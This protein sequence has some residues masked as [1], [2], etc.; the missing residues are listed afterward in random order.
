MEYG[1]VFPFS[2]LNAAAFQNAAIFHRRRLHG[3]SFTVFAPPE[4]LGCY[5]HAN[6]L[7]PIDNL[8]FENYSEVSNYRLKTLSRRDPLSWF[9][10]QLPSFYWQKYSNRLPRSCYRLLPAFLQADF[11]MRRY[12]FRSGVYSRVKNSCKQR[13]IEFLGSAPALNIESMRS[14]RRGVVVDWELW[15][16]QLSRMISS[17]AVLN[18]SEIRRRCSGEIKNL[19]LEQTTTFQQISSFIEDHKDVIM[20]R[21]R[22]IPGI[23]SAYNTDPAFLLSSVTCFLERGFSVINSGTPTIHLEI[24]HKNLLQVDHNL[25]VLVQQ[26]LG[27][28]CLYVMTSAEGGLFVAWA[29]TSI[30]LI[31]FGIEWSVANTKSCISLLEARKSIGIHDLNLGVT[32]GRGLAY[33]LDNFLIHANSWQNEHG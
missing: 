15:F 19:S 11:K 10:S 1:L 20:V 13:S 16:E 28:K 14:I 22:N 6:N 5:F 33:V 4:I 9:S 18:K 26:Y 30:P 25:P 17:G 21:T 2:E 32:Q 27:S 24:Q 8:P 29:A 23:A 12:L 7:V 31:T 3:D